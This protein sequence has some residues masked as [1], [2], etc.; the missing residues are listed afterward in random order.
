MAGN[1]M[2]LKNG[3]FVTMLLATPFFGYGFE[4]PQLDVSYVTTLR[5]LTKNTDAWTH[6][7]CNGQNKLTDLLSELSVII[8]TAHSQLQE[9]PDVPAAASLLK[10]MIKD[11]HDGLTVTHA[12]FSKAKSLADL[13]KSG[14][15]SCSLQPMLEKAKKDLD[16]LISHVKAHPDMYSK[17]VLESLEDYQKTT[18]TQFYNYW[19][20]KKWTHF[21]PGLMKIFRLR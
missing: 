18:F 19:A 20:P 6:K 17:E 1:R 7:L 8:T 16:I 9:I 11:L 5:T 13:N 15:T 4:E 21:L 12:T 2:K 14:A 3:L 10:T